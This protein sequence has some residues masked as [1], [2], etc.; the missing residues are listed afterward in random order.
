[1]FLALINDCVTSAVK[2]VPLSDTTNEGQPLLA[3]NQVKL[4]I[5]VSAFALCTTSKIIAL[6]AAQVYNET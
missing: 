6:V 1:M 5:N 4:Q 3:I 2:F